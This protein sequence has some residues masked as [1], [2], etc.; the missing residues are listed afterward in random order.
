MRLWGFL[1][2]NCTGDARTF[3]MIL[4]SLHVMRYCSIQT[5]YSVSHANRPVQWQRSHKNAG[6]R[7]SLMV[8][9]ACILSLVKLSNE[10]NGLMKYTL[11]VAKAEPVWFT[12]L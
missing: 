2:R 9:S 1:K 12:R 4:I 5:P 11:P 7:K 10:S 8:A 3:C 6:S